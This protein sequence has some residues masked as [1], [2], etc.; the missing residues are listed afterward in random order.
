MT[1]R[2]ATALEVVGLLLVSV[3]GWIIAPALGLL[4]AGLSFVAFGLA[5]S[6]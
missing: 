2:L 3:A 4:V 1:D 6:R 5:A